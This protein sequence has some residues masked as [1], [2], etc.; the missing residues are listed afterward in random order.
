MLI[1]D[2]N[3]QIIRQSKGQ[4]NAQG[5]KISFPDKVPENLQGRIVQG[6]VKAQ[7]KDGSF[8]IKLSSGETIRANI[9]PPPPVGSKIT[10]SIPKQGE[11]KVLELLTPDDKK[12]N[13]KQ[14]QQQ[15][16]KEGTAKQSAAAAATANKTATDLKTV[17]APQTTSKPAPAPTAQG[18]TASPTAVQNQAIPQT[19]AAAAVKT[20]LPQIL[21]NLLGKEISL[22]LPAKAAEVPLNIPAKEVQFALRVT[23]PPQG[24][25]A[26]QTLTPIAQPTMPTL[27]AKFPQPLPV[28][29]A[30][31]VQPTATSTPQ[32]PQVQVVQV[33]QAAPPPNLAVEASPAPVRHI[34]SSEQA[35]QVLQQAK[36]IVPKNLPA[37][38]PRNTTLHAT[39]VGTPPKVTTAG[40]VLQQS[41]HL[42]S[43]R[44]LTLQTPLPLPEG[45]TMAIRITTDGVSEILRLVNADGIGK[46]HRFIPSRNPDG[47]QD[48]IRGNSERTGTPLPQQP[49]AAKTP[50][51]NFTP[52]SI[53]I[54]TVVAQGEKGMHLLSFQDGSQLQVQAGRNFPLGA[55]ITITITAEGNAQILD[56]TLPSGTARTNALTNLSLRWEG[57]E[58]AMAELSNQRPDLAADFKNNLPHL[59][60][61]FLPSF[62]NFIDAISR[63]SLERF[64]GNETLNILRAMGVDLSG[65]MHGLNQLQQKGDNADSWRAL[66]FPYVEN[67]DEPPRQGGFFW[68]QDGGEDGENIHTRFVVNIALSNLGPMQLDGLMHE[69]DLT[70]KLRMQKPVDDTFVRE[71][72][73]VVR[74]ILDQADLTGDIHIEKTE[75]FDTDP[76]HDMLDRQEKLSVTI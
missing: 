63:E 64:A 40:Q 53:H 30:L 67:E 39:V 15:Q 19:A 41:V 51:Q 23:S 75:Y 16:T 36:I 76:L 52:N 42:P 32:Q 59:G 61:G 29:T 65:D 70:L 68:R 72:K 44:Q 45:T 3:L 11:A 38:F 73:S 20:E 2:A 66:L 48:V 18:Q 71:L 22:S 28:Q 14:P 62:I 25:A 74:Q 33:L 24:Q 8:Q 10:F 43:G 27:Q 1:D 21:T 12:T 57:L 50:L 6:E 58:K 13:D 49:S 5:M 9:E 46:H 17:A 56:I 69:Q 55:Q 34:L 47:G 54:G 37:D 31:V 4:R 26:T 7:H 35:T 60:K